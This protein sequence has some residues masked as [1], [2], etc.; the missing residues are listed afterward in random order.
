MTSLKDVFQL[1]QH[2]GWAVCLDLKDAYFHIPVHPRHRRF[3]QFIW[4]G[5]A[6]H[7]R[8]L[9]FGLF[10][11]PRTFTR[12]TKPIAHY[13]RSR[14]IHVVFYLD[15]V[16]ILARS[17]A[18]AG[19]SRRRTVRLLQSLGF[20]LNTEKSDLTLRQCFTYLGF[21]WDTQDLSVSLPQEKREEIQ[22]LAES[23]LARPS[24]T[25]RRLL[26]F[27]KVTFASYAVPLARLHTREL[28][29]AL[30][31]VYKHPGDMGKQVPLH[32]E[33][34]VNLEFWQCLQHTP[35]RHLPEGSGARRT[36]L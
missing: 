6:Y 26:T 18:M 12:V 3:L 35:R 10:S 13:L 27:G 34:R 1:V 7:Y 30:A 20:T 21:Q 16:L 36:M 2:N 29:T 8:C 5:Q 17:R 14:G 9:P 15:D 25:A 31:S 23:L 24:T 22:T 32:S 19:I 11:S 4:R 28:Q 33:A